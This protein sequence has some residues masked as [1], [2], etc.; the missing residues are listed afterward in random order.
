MGIKHKNK[1]NNIC[2]NLTTNGRI[3]DEL[4]GNSQNSFVLLPKN[5]VE[6]FK[7]ARIFFGVLTYV[8]LLDIYANS[9]RDRRT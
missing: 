4:C 9:L 5:S 7:V 8:I 1:N 3:S 6:F 2:A